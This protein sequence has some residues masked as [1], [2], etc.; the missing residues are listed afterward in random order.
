VLEPP[1]GRGSGSEAERAEEARSQ[2]SYIVKTGQSGRQ[3]RKYLHPNPPA[4][5]STPLRKPVK[6]KA[7]VPATVLSSE[8]P[9]RLQAKGLL[10]DEFLG[11]S[12]ETEAREAAAGGRRGTLDA[13]CIQ[14]P[15]QV[16]LQDEAVV[17]PA[18]S[19]LPAS[20]PQVLT[21]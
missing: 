21:A 8:A 14:P 11:T 3:G 17:S 5:A 2:Y 4:A 12:S 9:G 13:Y 18:R 1:E 7:A 10:R 19:A 15:G 16:F 6:Q 20:R